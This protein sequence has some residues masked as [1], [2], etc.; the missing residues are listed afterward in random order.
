[1]TKYILPRGSIW[2]ASGLKSDRFY[3]YIPNLFGTTGPAARGRIS[4]DSGR[5]IDSMKVIETY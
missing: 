3:K 5:K 2:V 1:M 4:A